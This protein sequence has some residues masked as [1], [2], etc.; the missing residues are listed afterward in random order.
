[1]FYIHRP[2]P[3]PELSP[4]WAPP[5]RAAIK[6]SLAAELCATNI[7]LKKTDGPRKRIENKLSPMY[8]EFEKHIAKM[9]QR[10]S[11]KD[12]ECDS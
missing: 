7:K 12:D 9:A 10:F 11:P 1:L 3:P 4:N 2:P 5:K 6:G 8:A